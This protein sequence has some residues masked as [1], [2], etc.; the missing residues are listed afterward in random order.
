[1][2]HL[3]FHGDREATLCEKPKDGTGL[4]SCSVGFLSSTHIHFYHKVVCYRLMRAEE[5]ILP[6]LLHCLL[7]NFKTVCMLWLEIPGVTH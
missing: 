2:Y 6:G 4:L 7:G 3:I 1:M 5:G